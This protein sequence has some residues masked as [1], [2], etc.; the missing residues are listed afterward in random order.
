[1]FGIVLWV[2]WSRGFAPIAKPGSNVQKLLGCLGISF[3]AWVAGVPITAHAFGRFSVGGLVANV[4][5]IYCAGWMVKCGVFGLAASFFC[6][7]LAAIANN[8]SG[9]CTFAMTL[10]SEQVANIDNENTNV[11]YT[12]TSTL[13]HVSIM[14]LVDMTAS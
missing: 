9:L 14:T 4:A 7:P 6:I 2:E 11:S 12:R 5:V 8:L 1:M 3:A 10:I 13:L